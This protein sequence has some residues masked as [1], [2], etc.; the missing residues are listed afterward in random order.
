[1]MQE[2]ETKGTDSLGEFKKRTQQSLN[3]K[4]CWKNSYLLRK[5]KGAET[6]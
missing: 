4:T 3:Q 2:S 5:Y 1:M 6:H